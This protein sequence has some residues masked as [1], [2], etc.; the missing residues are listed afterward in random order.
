[1]DDHGLVLA[2]ES[3]CHMCASDHGTYIVYCPVERL[4]NFLV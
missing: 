1:M 2:L 4:G 3:S